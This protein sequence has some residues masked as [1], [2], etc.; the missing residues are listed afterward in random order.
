[1][2]Y[3]GQLFGDSKVFSNFSNGWVAVN[4]LEVFKSVGIKFPS[5]ESVKKNPKQITESEK[6]QY[7]ATVEKLKTIELENRQLQSIEKLQAAEL[8]SLKAQA[9]KK[10]RNAQNTI[11]KQQES[12]E[13]LKLEVEKYKTESRILKLEL[14]K[15]Q[16]IIVEKDHE[17]AA[18]S[19]K[20][21]S[22][23]VLSN[24]CSELTKQNEH[25]K[26]K[27]VNTTSLERIVR[28]LQEEKQKL[29]N[30]LMSF[31]AQKTLNKE[32]EFKIHEFQDQIVKQKSELL[33]FNNLKNK[34][35]DI[36]KLN[37]DLVL[38]N[39][40]LSREALRLNDIFFEYEKVQSQYG[41]LKADY[42]KISDKY[43]ELEKSHKK[44]LNEKHVL[45]EQLSNE[46]GSAASSTNAQQQ[47]VNK[48]EKELKSA[49]R[50]IDVL[51]Q[52]VEKQKNAFRETF[53]ELTYRLKEY[54]RELK[55]QRGK[56]MQ[57]SKTLANA[58]MQKGE[59][60]KLLVEQKR[61]VALSEKAKEDA[62]EREAALAEALEKT[63]ITNITQLP[64]AE[65]N[66]VEGEVD[67]EIPNQPMIDM[68]T[69]G[70]LYQ[71][72][73]GK[74]WSVRG[75]DGVYGLFDLKDML[76]SRE[77]E[78]TTYVK[79]FGSWWKKFDE[80]TELNVDLQEVTVGGESHF[81]IKRDSIRVA[82]D[83]Y[84]KVSIDNRTF[85]G[86]ISDISMGGCFIKMGQVNEQLMSPGTEIKVQFKGAVLKEGMVLKCAI[87]RVINSEDNKGLAVQFIDLGEYERK[88]IDNYVGH[89]TSKLDIAS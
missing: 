23:T 43:L 17:I 38:D 11:T 37:E 56:S 60:E 35:A 76:L 85:D 80:V 14:M 79:K 82:I 31:E 46:R 9:F 58:K 45:F 89:M 42:R 61:L 70:S 16:K 44:I 66:D 77:I 5:E 33:S 55:E 68:S 49:N 57:L 15:E 73:T 28:E 74:I 2:I 87:R 22:L 54:Q 24:R 88:I 29:E 13:A 72:N 4:E 59:V 26:V 65:M 71:V 75:R 81:Y 6:M 40:R 32:L 48:Y 20:S 52:H 8:E 12:L 21:D 84:L 53:D 62:L 34:I 63:A 47:L 10:Y 18:L 7:E 69:L 78:R 86:T 50:K 39:E 30:D 64:L 41:E 25:L 36:Q 1:M 3:D 67:A 83:D 19:I 51:K 27:I